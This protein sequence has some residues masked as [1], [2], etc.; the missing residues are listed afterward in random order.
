MDITTV[1]DKYNLSLST[2]LSEDGLVSLSKAYGDLISTLQS[3]TDSQADREKIV[4][5][6]LLARFKNPEGILDVREVLAR[7]V[8][9]EGED[10]L[11]ALVESLQSV[12]QDLMVLRDYHVSSIARENKPERVKDESEVEIRKQ[13]AS[14]LRE[15]IVSVHALMGH[16]A[17]DVKDGETSLF[18]TKKNAEN[19]IVPDLPR[20]PGGNTTGNVGKGAKIRQMCYEIDGEKIPAGT[21]FY[22]V[23]HRYICDFSK[24]LVF[25]PLEVKDLVDKTGQNF[26]PE[27]YEN[28]WTI[29]IGG[30]IF[31]GWLP[32]SE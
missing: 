29:E 27:G 21:L 17:L 7:L 24:G 28:K 12:K 15:A 1:L 26:T 2:V 31:S 9:R 13:E 16:P 11:P 3:D 18:K 23:I 14:A 8:E 4:R 20:V 19:K 22:N 30:R 6:D 25:K 32:P 10:V 5:D